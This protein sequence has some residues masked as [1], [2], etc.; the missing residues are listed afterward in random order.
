MGITNLDDMLMKSGLNIKNCYLS[1][2][3]NPQSMP[4]A[5]TFSWTN[6][7]NNNKTYYAYASVY[8]FTSEAAKSEGKDPI[9]VNSVVIPVNEQAVF[10]VLYDSL[11]QQYPN[12]QNVPDQTEN[13]DSS[14]APSSHP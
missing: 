3:P 5:I 4:T 6:D 8:I 12:Y 11:K 14:Q 1:F 2:T 7:G 9:E 10:S 13:S